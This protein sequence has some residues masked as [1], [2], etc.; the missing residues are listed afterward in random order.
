MADIHSQPASDQYRDNWER[1]FGRK[2][3]VTVHEALEFCGIPV[4]INDSI[5]KDEIWLMSVNRID[6][7]VNI[8]APKNA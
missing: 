1:I 8:G 7:I 6:K 4:E 3:T 5:P 2:H